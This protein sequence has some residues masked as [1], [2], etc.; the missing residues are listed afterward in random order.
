MLLF[1]LGILLSVGLIVHGK[2]TTP[3]IQLWV[4]PYHWRSITNMLMLT[5][6]IF[7]AAGNLPLS[8]LKE[9]L[10][11]PMLLGVVVW[12]ASHLL[13]NGDLA[14]LLLFGGLALWAGVKIITLQLTRAHSSR[15]DQ[16]AMRTRR[17]S[18][19]WDAAAVAM[20]TIV[21][22]AI[23]LFHGPL[24]GFALIPAA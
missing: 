4:P 17:P 16:Q 15:P 22:G 2:S 8:Y 14:S 20:G 7:M 11:H 21:Y 18:L 24:F 23:L 10:T 9:S 12:G 5:A 1:C 13:S 3:F 19:Y 6:C